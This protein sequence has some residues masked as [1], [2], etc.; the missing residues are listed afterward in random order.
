MI[1]RHTYIPHIAKNEKK[2]IKNKKKKNVR[3]KIVR[4]KILP[5]NEER[6]VPHI[7]IYTVITDRNLTDADKK[8]RDKRD[9][10]KKK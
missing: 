9:K 3:K 4:Q 2:K 8:R 1:K 7:Y 10:T 6:F 5:Q